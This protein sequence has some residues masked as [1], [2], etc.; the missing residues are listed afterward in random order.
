MKKYL[1]ALLGVFGFAFAHPGHLL[2]HTDAFTSGLL[3]PITGIDH[4][5][6]MVAV[7]MLGA[8]LFGK[9]AFIPP[10]VFVS[11]MALGFVLGYYGVNIPFVENGILLSVALS[12]LLLIL[13]N[14]RLSFILPAL[15]IFGLFHGI[16]HGY[17]APQ[18]NP[19]LFALG[20]ILS[21]STLH[22]SGILI[23]KLGRER[24]VRVSGLALLALAFLL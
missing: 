18:G 8:Y 13:G 7:G 19:H 22:V 17:E 2:P 21:T 12:G 20:F 4:L 23:G 1:G 9:K 5:A 11:S 14:S 15:M 3:H 24:L 6:V 10:A 16:A